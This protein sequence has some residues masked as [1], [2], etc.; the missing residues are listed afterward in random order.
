MV[1]KFTDA[2]DYPN[3][4]W[5]EVKLTKNS[6]DFPNLSR[7]MTDCYSLCAGSWLVAASSLRISVQNIKFINLQKA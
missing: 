3:K 6:M 4:G 5:T 1:L 2:T 7:E